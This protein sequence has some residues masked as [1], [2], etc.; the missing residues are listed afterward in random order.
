MLWAA[1]Q[2][3][4]GSALFMLARHSKDVAHL[5]QA[6]E[7]FDL[8]LGL[9]EARNADNLAAI[10]AKNLTRVNKMLDDRQPKGGPRMDWEPDD[11]PAA[12]ESPLTPGD[13]D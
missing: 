13:P 1:T 8:A 10:T 6:A 2:N 4:L 11:A 9:Y 3:N 12:V 7:A 5:E